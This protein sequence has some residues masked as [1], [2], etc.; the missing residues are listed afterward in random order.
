M[1]KV[2]SSQR[3]TLEKDEQIAEGNSASLINNF[4]FNL[5][6]YLNKP[7]ALNTNSKIAKSSRY[8]AN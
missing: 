3:Q 6:D 8:K 7:L 4:V 1:K 2:A 5:K